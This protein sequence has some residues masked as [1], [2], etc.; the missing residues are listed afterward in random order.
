MEMITFSCR[1][2][3]GDIAVP[4]DAI[5]VIC[6]KC[7]AQYKITFKDGILSA[8]KIVGN[9]QFIEDPIHVQDAVKKVAIVSDLQRETYLTEQNYD[10]A[11]N[12]L[13]GIGF[14]I[15]III[16]IS[17]GFNAAGDYL[18]FFGVLFILFLIIGSIVL[19]SK[20]KK[21][22]QAS[23]LRDKSIN[24]LIKISD[25]QQIKTLIKEKGSVPVRE[26]PGIPF[27]IIGYIS[28]NENYEIIAKQDDWIQIQTDDECSLGWIKVS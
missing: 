6:K 15:L 22:K 18:V 10:L 3:D 21:L 11:F 13:R 1:N 23:Q 8:T 17:F 16:I 2:C 27:R 19:E 25:S 26:Y 20:R 12:L 4:S 9:S 24:V 14:I 28:N 7:G 5:L